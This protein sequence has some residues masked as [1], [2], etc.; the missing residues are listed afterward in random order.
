[1]LF[2]LILCVRSSIITNNAIRGTHIS[3]FKWMNLFLSFLAIVSLNGTVQSEDLG[4]KNGPGRSKAACDAGKSWGCD[5]LGTIYNM[6]MFS[7]V[8]QDYEIVRDHFKRQC[9]LGKAQDCNSLGVLYANGKGVIRDYKKAATLYN[10]ACD[11]DV[12]MGCLNIGIFH[13][14]GLGL[15]KNHNKA[16]HYY[17]MACNG[18]VTWGCN[19]LNEINQ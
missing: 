2:I 19:R 5:N 4:K 16:V 12:A 18:G 3:K 1:M 10:Q 6:R 14:K 8:D 15:K 11:N 13:E 9:D 7:G 17:T